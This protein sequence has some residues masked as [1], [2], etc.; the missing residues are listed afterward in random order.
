MTDGTPDETSNEDRSRAERPGRAGAPRR[1][2]PTRERPRRRQRPRAAT[3]PQIL[4]A[5]VEANAD[6]VA[7]VFRDESG[8][9]TE[10]TYRELDAASSKLA[11]ELIARGIGA[12]DVVALAVTRSAESI[13]SIW[14]VA[15]TGAAYVP[16]DPKYPA[17]RIEYM[18][19][20]SGATLGITTTEHRETLPE[21]VGPSWLV[22]GDADLDAAVDARSAEPVTYADRVR[23]LG[24]ANTAYMIYTSGSTGRPKGVEVTHAGLSSLVAEQRER[25][26]IDASARTLAVASP[27][28]DASVFEL[29]MAVGSGATMVVSP[30]DVF[31][32]DDLTACCASSG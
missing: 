8:A 6:G 25:F 7:L 24:P 3:L 26:G 19:T 10:W 2:R 9:T 5:A 32:G 23:V 21:G 11:R 22:L 30:P 31:G 12:E 14:A 1:E 18:L 17:D 20:D 27:S 16:V 28:F 29:L 15:K 13:L 4:A